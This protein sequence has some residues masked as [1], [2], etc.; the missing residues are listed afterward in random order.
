MSAPGVLFDSNDS[1]SGSSV[2]SMMDAKRLT[3][4]LVVQ[5]ENV[6]LRAHLILQGKGAIAL[7]KKS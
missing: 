6:L 2:E 4:N 1:D 3:E 7:G 5:L